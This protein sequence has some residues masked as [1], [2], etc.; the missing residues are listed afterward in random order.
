MPHGTALKVPPSG[1]TSVTGS[2]AAMALRNA[3]S[4]CAP[5]VSFAR[6][7]SAAV[8]VNGAETTAIDAITANTTPANKAL[9]TR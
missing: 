4:A 1:W 9:G 6:S 5:V 7:A 8:A 3:L 2:G